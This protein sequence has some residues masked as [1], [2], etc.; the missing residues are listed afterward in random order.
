MLSIPVNYTP[1]ADYCYY[2]I[3]KIQYGHVYMWHALA[4]YWGGVLVTSEDMMK[5]NPKLEH[6]VQSPGNIGNV[7]D[8]AIDSLEKY[9]GGLVDPTKIYEFY[10]NLHGYLSKKG[11]YGVK[12]DVQ[13]L[14]E[15]LGL[16]HG[17]RVSLSRKYQ[18]ALEESIA[19]NF[20]DNSIIC[21]MCHNSDSIYRYI[22]FTLLNVSLGLI[23]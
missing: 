1:N 18:Q 9:G 8:I 16:G 4:G 11:T 2:N 14:I 19:K 12:V 10:N 5:Y 3:T 20:P 22:S 17:G 13:N 23:S 15:T 21:C 6:P 7:R